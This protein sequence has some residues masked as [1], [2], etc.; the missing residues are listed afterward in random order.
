M[1]TAHLV[2]RVPRRRPP[3]QK[4]HT[5]HV[6]GWRLEENVARNE[7]WRDNMRAEL[8]AV[9]RMYGCQVARSI[10]ERTVEAWPSRLLGWLG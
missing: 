10:P 1:L 3:C 4:L 5:E 8:I 6:R 2:G 7:S 9:C